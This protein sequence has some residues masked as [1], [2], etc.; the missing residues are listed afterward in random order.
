MAHPA[1][2]RETLVAAALAFTAGFVDTCGFI[3]LFGLFTAHVTGNFVMIGA[4]IARGGGGLLAKL[5]ALPVFVL[6]VAAVR[7]WQRSRAPATAS[8]LLLLQA[9]LLTVFAGMGVAWPGGSPDA[10]LAI[11]TGMV[12]VA[13]M[14]VQNAAGRGPFAGLAPTTVM[15]GN[16]TQLTIDL[17]DLAAGGGP[18]RAELVARVRR[19]WPTVVFF[20]T[21]A[22]AAALCLRAVG[23]GCLAIPI[24]AVLALAAFEVR[25]TP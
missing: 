7:V 4:A 6:V 17:V 25:R 12:G 8:L 21:G 14:A 2:G 22:I 5:L 1:Y 20:A 16:V 18:T 19:M 10:P 3:S 9:A 11:A 13:A 23:F 15:T 24:L